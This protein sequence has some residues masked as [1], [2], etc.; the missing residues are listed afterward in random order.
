MHVQYSPQ[1]I[2]FGSIHGVT[3]TLYISKH[4]ILDRFY[5]HSHLHNS[6]LYITYFA[7]NT[8]IDCA[9]NCLKD[10]ADDY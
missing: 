4:N 7:S 5:F 1:R 8:V 6:Q 3:A 2:I 9:K 10:Y